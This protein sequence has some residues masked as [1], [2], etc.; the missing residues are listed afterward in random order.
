MTIQP[1]VLIWTVICFCILMLILNNLLFKPMLKIIDER[2]EKI[3]KARQ[4]K[5]EIDLSKAEYEEALAKRREDFMKSEAE[6]AENTIAVA[7]KNAEEMIR[8]AENE[9]KKRLELAK[10]DIE[11]EKK[12]LSEKLDENVDVLAKSFISRLTI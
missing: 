8:S 11:F 10:L 6:R 5:A 9:S 3:V 1:S 2:R 12:E 4:K 7:K